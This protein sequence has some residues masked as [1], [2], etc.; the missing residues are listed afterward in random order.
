MDESS[1]TEDK[2][3]FFEDL[4]TKQKLH[5]SEGLSK[6]QVAPVVADFLSEDT[7]VAVIF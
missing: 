4:Y 3:K 5:I 2:S 1:L 6:P 7:E